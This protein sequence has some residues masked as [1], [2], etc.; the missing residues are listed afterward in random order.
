M[1]KRDFQVNPI[2]NIMDQDIQQELSEYEIRMAE[3]HARY[4]VSKVCGQEDNLTEFEKKQVERFE[5]HMI[6]ELTD[7]LESSK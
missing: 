2:N 6:S 7:I 3:L 1:D 4:T 5:N